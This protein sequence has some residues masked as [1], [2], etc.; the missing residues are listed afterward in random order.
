MSENDILFIDSSHV[1]K[2]GSDVSYLLLEVLPAL[3][4]GVLVHF[5]DI[6]ANFD[7]SELWLREG[8]AWN[9][10]YALKAFLLH[11]RDFRIGLAWISQRVASAAPGCP[12]SGRAA[13]P[14]SSSPA[15]RARK[16]WQ[17]A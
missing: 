3:R 13:P 16:Q 17:R 14:N 12:P 1:M 5:H 2:F 6:F 8:R 4:P 11:N 15:P 7:Y 9:E 10:G